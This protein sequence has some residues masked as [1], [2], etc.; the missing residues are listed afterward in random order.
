MA[1]RSTDTPPLGFR[2]PHTAATLLG[3]VAGAVTY[4]LCILVKLPTPRYFP[5][6]G[7]WDLGSHAGSISMGYYGNLLVSALALGLAYAVGRIPMV[8]RGLSKP[9][10]AAALTWVSAVVFIGCLGTQLVH[11]LMRWASR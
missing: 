8:Q 9:K 1:T 6:S 4:T 2:S 11:E 3:A 10:P 7:T 5:V